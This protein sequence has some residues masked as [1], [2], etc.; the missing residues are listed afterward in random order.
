MNI[1]TQT[2]TQTHTKI[3][4]PHAQNKYYMN[5]NPH[6]MPKRLVDSF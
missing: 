5:Y 6:S 2:Q 4:E 1:D 3:T